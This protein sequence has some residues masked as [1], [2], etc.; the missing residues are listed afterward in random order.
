ME[1]ARGRK[2]KKHYIANNK[3]SEVL[4]KPDGTIKDIMHI[5]LVFNHITATKLFISQYQWKPM[6]VWQ[7][8]AAEKKTCL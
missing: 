6:F 1:I 4:P 7:S 3:T 8:P 5:I 2:L